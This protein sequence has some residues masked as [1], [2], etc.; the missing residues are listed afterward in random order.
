MIDAA[1][2]DGLNPRQREAVEDRG[3]ALLIVAGAGSGKT[4]V[5]TRRIAGL[6]AT[7]EA[8]PSQIL[9]IT[10]T[11]KAAAEMRERIQHLVGREA[12]EGMWIST[13]HSAC[14]RI[15]RRQAEAMGLKE[16]FTIY[17]AA[18]SKALVK[19]LIRELD[20]DSL[21][22][23]PGGVLA[24]ISRLK[25]ELTDPDEFARVADE[26]DP[27]E[28]GLLELY[29][30]YVAALRR[31]NA[32]DFD[33]LIGET[34]YL[35]R[36]FPDVA[37][38]YR[39]RFR[40][41]L[42]DE[43]QDTNHAQYALI[44][45]LVAPVDADTADRVE[46][47]HGF[48]RG[49]RAPD[50]SI[51]GAS[52]T[53]VGDSDQSIYAFRGAD[54]RNIVEFEQDFPDARVI[55]LEQNYRS[56]QTIL[57]AANAVIANNF[58]RKAK[59]L[60]TD[61][62]AGERIIGYTGYSGHDEAQFVADE[63][64]GL[65]RTGVAY[66]E[67]AVFV[68]T[69]A[70][71]RPLEEVFIREGVPYRLVG[72]TRFYE[73]AEVKDAFAY[74]TMSIN[75]DDDLALRRIINVPRRGIGEATVASLQARADREG[76]PLREVLREPETLGLGPKLTL[77]IGDLNRLI[78]EAALLAT[79]VVPG[80]AAAADE[81]IPPRPPH[82]V[83]T[84]LLTKSG[85]H[86]SLADS[87]D[88]QDQARAE[89][90]DELV[91]QAKEFRVQNP[92]GTTVDYL[93]SVALYAAADEIEGEAGGKVTIMTLHTAKGL[94]YD[95]VFITGVE[96]ALL[97]H[98][99]SV[100]DPGGLS[101]ERRLF[102]VGITRA[103][104]RLFLSLATS[105]AAYGDVN[106]ALPSRF[107]S[108][109]PAELI[110]WRDSG[111]SAVG[112]GAIGSRGGARG[113]GGGS[114]WEGGG[115]G[116]SGFRGGYRGGAGAR[117]GRPAPTFTTAAPTRPKTEWSTPLTTIRD[118]GDLKLAA[119]DR[120]RHDD[121]GEGV[122]ANVIENGPRTVAEVEFESRGRKRLLVKVAPITKL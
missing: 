34:V 114:D 92:A 110:D 55:L 82:E 22:F 28:L 105:R 80:A 102:Y 36:A 51:P 20:A 1:L 68:R 54:I 59:N 98:R 45:E 65:R 116:G 35:V 13:F 89:N 11:N 86:A 41:V 17:D 120:I 111:S 106:I 24:R 90:L 91:S 60:F 9:A 97:P 23:T 84:H 100:N 57:D 117:G 101:E 56:T 6:L 99:M 63:I 94:E 83:L 61:I 29:R 71:T 74:L 75:P 58:D 87:D 43:Y 19:R 69:N 14:V 107:L 118:N 76:V 33:D 64:E 67:V 21:G 109:I 5:L 62:G 39:R 38:L 27:K 12:A 103:R 95:A 104:K 10:F 50:G 122:V 16:G 113:I 44:R 18:D 42:V 72:G 93:T 37:A 85:L 47:L 78:D 121:F 79:G 112:G 77:A 46:E 30:R 49:L 70:Q 73:R 3:R 88:P 4:S 2:L 53:V 31:A 108:E 52:L 7:R 40:H 25:N 15:L 26:S 115:S 81:R 66:P 32:L 96:E 119:G 48:Q 8:F